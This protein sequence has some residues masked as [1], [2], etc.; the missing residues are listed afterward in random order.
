MART[1]KLAAGD[2]EL[3][4]AAAG[5]VRTVTRGGD[6]SLCQEAGRELIAVNDCVRERGKQ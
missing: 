6:C 3:L 5:E 1:G 4:G 2:L